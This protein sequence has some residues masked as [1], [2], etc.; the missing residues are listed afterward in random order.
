MARS[1]RMIQT[2]VALVLTLYCRPSNTLELL[3]NGFNITKPP[4]LFN[5]TL[6][7]ETAQQLP[8]PCV[9]AYTTPINCNVTILMSPNLP[10]KDS[11]LEESCNPECATSLLAFERGVRDACHGVNLTISD[12]DTPWLGAVI[13]GEAAILLYWKQC[14]RDL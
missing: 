9:A 3:N 14:L 10:E 1:Y 8:Q 7:S 13:D 2:I 4:W 6:R 12:P 5:G 11:T